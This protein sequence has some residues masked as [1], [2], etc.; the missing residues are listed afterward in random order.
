[1]ARAPRNAARKCFAVIVLCT[2]AGVRCFCYQLPDI[3]GRRILGNRKPETGNRKPESGKR[4]AESGKRKPETGI[5]ELRRNAAPRSRGEAGLSIANGDS[6]SV[7]EQ[8]LATR[9]RELFARFRHERRA[10]GAAFLRRGG[11]GESPQP[12][13]EV[14]CAPQNPE[15]GRRSKSGRGFGRWEEASF[16][17]PSRNCRGSF[18][19]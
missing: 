14:A 13:R 17:V 7:R 12:A 1:M 4:K 6:E 15:A 2:R 8:A 3:L 5:A 18:A 9:R 19:G 10:T 16:L 11:C